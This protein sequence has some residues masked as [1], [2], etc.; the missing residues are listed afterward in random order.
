MSAKKLGNIVV[1][2]V[3]VM[4]LLP[5][6]PFAKD[7]P[8]LMDLAQLKMKVTVTEVIEELPADSSAYDQDDKAGHGPF[9]AGDG[10]KI[11]VVTLKGNA[12][13]PCSITFRTGEFAAVYEQD[14]K[15]GSE[16][17]RNTIIGPAVALASGDSWSVS[18]GT[19]TMLNLY[20]AGP[21]VLRLAFVVPDAVSDFQVRYP[22]LTGGKAVIP[23]KKP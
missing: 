1:A 16:I 9:V 14:G 11:V 10:K 20:K 19:T 13:R 4:L 6:S 17:K 22:T 5:G 12:P 15:P 7:L 2:A 18:P 21:L 8:P 3:A 23:E